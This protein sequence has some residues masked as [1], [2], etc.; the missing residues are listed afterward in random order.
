MKEKDLYRKNQILHKNGRNSIKKHKV[1]KSD[2]NCKSINQQQQT[3]FTDEESKILQAFSHIILP[4]PSEVGPIII[5]IL[6]MRNWGLQNKSS[7]R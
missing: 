3:T 2:S 7:Q 1:F 5:P 4:V 6:Q